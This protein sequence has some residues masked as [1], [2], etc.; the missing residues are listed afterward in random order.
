MVL[1]FGPFLLPAQRQRG[2][3]PCALAVRSAAAALSILPWTEAGT[4]GT[5]LQG[6]NECLVLAN[7]L[8][9]LL[10]NGAHT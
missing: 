8:L 9:E 5:N 6:K 10:G 3:A 1:E 7:K 4:L 2:T